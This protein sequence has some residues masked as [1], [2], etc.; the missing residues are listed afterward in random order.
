MPNSAIKNIFKIKK[1]LKNGVKLFF[2]GERMWYNAYIKLRGSLVGAAVLPDYGGRVSKI[3]INTK[4][5][6]VNDGT[7]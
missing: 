4:G 3:R 6:K 7:H 2:I 5:G 1:V